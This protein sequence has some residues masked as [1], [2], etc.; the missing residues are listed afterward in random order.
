MLNVDNDIYINIASMGHS[1]KK[2]ANSKYNESIY[3]LV[4]LLFYAVVVPYK[5]Y[6]QLNL[7]APLS[8][9][10]PTSSFRHGL[11]RRS[12]CSYQGQ[13]II[14]LLLVVLY[15]IISISN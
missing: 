9:D 3:V 8:D 1:H 11:L 6:G 7:T 12:S 5:T 2:N 14:L 15:F 13:C 10:N 4:I